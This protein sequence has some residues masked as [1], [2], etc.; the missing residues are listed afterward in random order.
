MSTPVFDITARHKDLIFAPATR[1]H[2]TLTA[3]GTI[4]PDELISNRDWV[5]H[6]V[7]HARREVAFALMPPGLDL[8]TA[9]FIYAEQHDRAERLAFLPFDAFIELADALPDPPNVVFVF[10]I[11]RCGS[12][13]ISKIFAEVPGVW[14]LSEP[15]PYS[16]ITHQRHTFDLDTRV[17]LVRATTR[18]LF[19]PPEGKDATTFVLKFRS[20]SSFDMEPFFLAF[21]KAHN[22]FLWREP[23]GW[24]N[25]F[26]LLAQLLGDDEARNTREF[27]DLR[28]KWQT[29]EADRA[30]YARFDDLDLAQSRD[31]PL[32]AALWAASLETYLEAKAH[33]DRIEA[34]SYQ[35]LNEEREATVTRLLQACGLPAEHLGSAMRAYERHSQEDSIVSGMRDARPLSAEQ[36]AEIAQM[37]AGHPAL[38][39]MKG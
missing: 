8:G 27:L 18:A 12:T 26:Y 22:L 6:F 29:A 25:S 15:D 35:Q 30:L 4:E 20:Y 10:N 2:Y 1:E 28:W 3:G 33:G 23:I 14:S 38:D 7:D 21:P 32:F 17:A 9:P 11:G 36:R 13:L 5:L 39:L 19:R 34:F 31:E 24:S 37:L 16:Q